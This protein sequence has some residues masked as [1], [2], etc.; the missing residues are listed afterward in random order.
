MSADQHLADHPR[1]YDRETPTIQR[2]V[3]AGVFV[4]YQFSAGPRVAGSFGVFRGFELYLGEMRDTL[5]MKA[6]GSTPAM[7]SKTTRFMSG[8]NI[9]L[10][11]YA[12]FHLAGGLMVLSGQGDTKNMSYTGALSLQLDAHWLPFHVANTR[13]RINYPFGIGIEWGAL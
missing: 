7:A 8:M 1:A 13:V 3:T 5:T 10:I 4:D 12:G 9:A 11:S 2:F 6:V